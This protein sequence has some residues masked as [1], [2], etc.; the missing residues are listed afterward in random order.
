MA[1]GELNSGEA[2]EA[3][4][5]ALDVRSCSHHPSFAERPFHDRNELPEVN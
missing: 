1:L 4:F 5:L 3:S 2:S